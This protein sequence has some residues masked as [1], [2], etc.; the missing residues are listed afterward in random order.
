MLKSYLGVYLIYFEYMC[1]HNSVMY[2]DVCTIVFGGE[3]KS[4]KEKKGGRQQEGD[5]RG[6]GVGRKERMKQI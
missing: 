2:V 5:E 6:Q 3:G 1:V 4:E